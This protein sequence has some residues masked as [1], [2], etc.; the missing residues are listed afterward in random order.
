MVSAS[1]SGSAKVLAVLGPTNTGKTHLAVERM[2]GHRDGVIGLPLRLLAREIYDRIA[3]ARGANAVAL[4]TGEE[5]IVPAHARYFVCTVEAM[6]LDRE[7]AFLAVDEIQLAADPDR[8]HVFTDRLLHARGSEETMFLGAETVRGLIR[9]LVPAAE[10]IAR[11]RFSALTYAGPKKLSRLPPRSAIVAFSAVEVYGIAD[12]IR[13]QRGGAAVV[14]GALSPRTRNA[15][16]ALFEDGEVD[17]MV[18]TDAIGMGLNLNVNHVAFASVKKF[19]GSHYRPL[20]PS[21]L[22]QIAGRAGR[23]MNAGT[24]G[25]TG[26]AGALDPETIEAVEAHRFDPLASLY[27]RNTGLEFRSV[28]TLIKCLEARPVR[29]ELVRAP[30]AEDERSLRAIVELPDIAA[31]AVTPGAIRM[32]WDVCQVP[33]YRKTL[34]DAHVPLLAQ[35]Y[36]HLM[37]PARRIP[38]DWLSGHIDRL[39]R[40]DGDIDTLA[41]RIAHIRTWTYVAHRLDWLDDPAFWQERARA[42]EDRLSDALHERLTQR[43][44]DRRAG[45]ISRK[46][47]SAGEVIAAV[48]ADGEV[49]VEGHTVGRLEGLRFIADEAAAGEDG[50]VFRAAALKALPGPTAERALALVADADEAFALNARAQIEWRGAAVARLAAGADPLTPRVLLLPNDFLSAE[51]RAQAAAR[52]ERWLRTHV[53]REL[54]PLVVLVGAEGLYGV[55]RGIAY[56]V[57]RSAGL[58]PRLAVDALLASLPRADRAALKRLGITIGRLAVYV[59]ALLKPRRRAL[60]SLLDA[61]HRERDTAAW[62]GESAASFAASDARLGEPPGFIRLGARWVR[63]DLA[64][65]LVGELNRL[66]TG[67]GAP[68]LHELM[69]LV[70]CPRAEFEP[71]VKALGFR[72]VA[73]EGA[74]VIRRRRRASR[75][76]ATRAG[77]RESPFAVLA[78]LGRTKPRRPA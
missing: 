9:K 6:P 38:T 3:A 64:E 32:L 39:D 15:Q 52:T 22:A 40:I 71:V 58:A 37:A 12:L 14:L 10:F 62:S 16:V 17:Y 61:V 55:A 48:A 60:L 78:R 42:I 29:R 1:R 65:R 49:L 67:G 19:D 23:H 56:E 47:K 45:A 63:I 7:F 43:F 72:A 50:R 76:P 28:G 69:A 36:R 8:G 20:A 27:W 34:A 35:I 2:L 59:P 74:T 24:F 13:R 73:H 21:E 4:V 31:L 5:K 44:V 41:T 30:T 11:P 33:D 53:A 54:A 25:T 75:A 70:G 26:E 57:A 68:K 51:V 66:V 46:L 77:N 18:A